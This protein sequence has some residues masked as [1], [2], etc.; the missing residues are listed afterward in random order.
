MAQEDDSVIEE[1][2]YRSTLVLGLPK[3]AIVQF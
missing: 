2:E 3:P 1:E